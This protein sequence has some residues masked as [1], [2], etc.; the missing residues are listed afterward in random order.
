V[1]GLA[2][3]TRK[4]VKRIVFGPTDFPQ[5][6]AIG[7]HDPQSEVS[8]WMRGL[9]APRD[10]T[11]NHV[12]A[13]AAPFT[14]GIGLDGKQS[15]ALAE[16]TQ[17]WLEFRERTAEGQLLVKM[18]LQLS[19]VLPVGKHELYLF[20]VRN[21]RNYCLPRLRLWARYLH[22][23]YQQWRQ[24]PEIRMSARDTHAMVGF[25]ACPRPVALVSVVDG[26]VGNI[27]PMNLMGPVG[28]SHFSLALNST[29]P[30]TSLLARAG[31]VA[32]SSIPFQ[33][34]SLAYELAKNHKR[35]GVDWKRLAFGTRSSARLNLPVPEFS[36]R[37]REMR[38]EAVRNMGSHTLFLARILHDERWA[39]GLQFF[40]VHGMYQAWKQSTRTLTASGA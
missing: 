37:V 10:V 24:V 2:T 26:E 7:L 1:M 22:S 4:I 20:R 8:V 16:S 29:R 32:L 5:Q 25:F 14:I 6:C 39:D 9:G 18:E 12:M 40:T 17:L 13:C 30:V 15:G 34:A 3:Q 19:A 38:I 21:C 35:E 28:N 27:F 11:Q 36:L 31:E 33:Q 23:A